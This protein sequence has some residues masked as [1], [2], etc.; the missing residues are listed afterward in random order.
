VKITKDYALAAAEAFRTLP[1]RPESKETP[2]HFVFVSGEGVTHRPTWST[3]LFGRVKGETELALAEMRRADPRFKVD[4]VRPGGVDW[5]AHAA[6]HP[7]V[8]QGWLRE[9]VLTALSPLRGMA[10]AMLSPTEPLGRFLT[11]AAMGK[12]E[13]RMDGAGVEVVG[14]TGMRVVRN[15]G[16][17]RLAG[18]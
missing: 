1:S 9:T 2:F 7:Y 14:D 18:L 13:G 11:E 12:W 16:F 8:N 5:K 6:I 3:T 10:K 15:T 17:L 4:T